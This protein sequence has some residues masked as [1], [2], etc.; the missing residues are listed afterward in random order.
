MCVRAC[1][2][3]CLCVFVFVCVCVCVRARACVYVGEE[4]THF[5]YHA[6]SDKYCQ[7]P[8]D[9]ALRSPVGEL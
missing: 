1:V 4:L 2:R 5:R 3:V 8:A 9:E 6:F 7:T